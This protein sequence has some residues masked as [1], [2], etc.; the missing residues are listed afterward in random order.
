[1]KSEPEIKARV[2]QAPGYELE[3]VW[4]PKIMEQQTEGEQMSERTIEWN[5]KGLNAFD[6]GFIT[7][8]YHQIRAGSHLTPKQVTAARK[9]LPKYARQYRQMMT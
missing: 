7:S 3:L 1:M 4:I 9:V 5:Q 2:S 8:L 6:A